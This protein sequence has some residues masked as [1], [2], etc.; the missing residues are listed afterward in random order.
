MFSSDGLSFRVLFEQDLR[1]S[2]RTRE[3]WMRV[4]HNT[5]GKIA[6]EQTS[7]RTRSKIRSQIAQ[8][9]HRSRCPTVQQTDHHHIMHI[10]IKQFK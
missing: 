2:F 1:S 3:S 5:T 4:N 6:Q 7:H 10:N 9:A 8:R